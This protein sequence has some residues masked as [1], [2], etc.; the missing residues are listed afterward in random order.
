MSEIGNGRADMGFVDGAQHDDAHARMPGADL[1]RLLKRR[2]AECGCTCLEHGSREQLD[3][4]APFTQ[5]GH[6]QGDRVD[7]ELQV[8]AEALV[9]YENI[10]S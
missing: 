4:L 1:E 2:H 9:A 8:A 5:R 6:G 7:A 3:V 10:G